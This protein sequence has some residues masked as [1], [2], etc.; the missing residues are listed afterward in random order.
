M[1]C[2]SLGNLER[3]W[4]IQPSRWVRR[5]SW[6][7]TQ[8]ACPM[9]NTQCVAKLY[10]DTRRHR[11]PIARKYTGWEIGGLHLWSRRTRHKK[12]YMIPYSRIWRNIP[13]DIRKAFQLHLHSLLIAREEHILYKK[14]SLTLRFLTSWEWNERGLDYTIRLKG[15]SLIIWS[16]GVCTFCQKK[17]VVRW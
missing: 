10:F 8:A 1:P 11:W 5:Q 6:T 7:D 15:L 14:V 17:W 2:I 12:N 13:D 4:P 9:P 16:F 3:C